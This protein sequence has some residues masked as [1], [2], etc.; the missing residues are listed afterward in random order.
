MQGISAAFVNCL[1][2]LRQC[3]I[4]HPTKMQQEMDHL[5]Q[6]FQANGVLKKLVKMTLTT[7]PLL[8]PGTLEPQQQPRIQ[9]MHPRYCAPLTSEGFFP[10]W[11]EACLQTHKNSE[12]RTN[13]CEEQDLRAETDRSGV[14]DS[15]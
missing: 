4:C 3:N 5:N 15:L 13:V 1:Q 8:L 11:G 12:K 6:V 10:L 9:M 14:R 2:N 7:R